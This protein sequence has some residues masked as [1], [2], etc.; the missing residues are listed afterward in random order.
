[1][2]CGELFHGDDTWARSARTA[3]PVRESRDRVRT[4]AEHGSCQRFGIQWEQRWLESVVPATGEDELSVFVA[5]VNSL[6]R[7]TLGLRRT[8]RHTGQGVLDGSPSGEHH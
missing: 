2:T 6:R 4:V 8:V 7:K 1:M 3:R 5:E